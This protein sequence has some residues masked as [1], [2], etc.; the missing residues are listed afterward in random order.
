MLPP[1]PPP[2]ESARGDVVMSPTEPADSDCEAGNAQLSHSRRGGPES[3]Q[4]SWMALVPTE[5]SSHPGS[6]SQAPTQ[7]YNVVPNPV[8]VTG[9]AAPTLLYAEE[10]NEEQ[11]VE[12]HAKEK[13]PEHRATSDWQ[14]RAEAMFDLRTM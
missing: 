1:V 11:W 12:I 3:S 9:S 13:P 2:D 5:H 8:S 6:V 4:G 14:E 10:E 7:E